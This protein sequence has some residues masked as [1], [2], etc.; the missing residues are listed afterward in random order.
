MNLAPA[1]VSGQAR[2]IDN[3]RQFYARHSAICSI[4]WLKQDAASRKYWPTD[5]V[6]GRGFSRG[7]ESSAHFPT[8]HPAAGLH[9]ALANLRC[10]DINQ[11]P[12]GTH[13]VVAT[14]DMQ[15]F[16]RDTAR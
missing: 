4:S 8:T 9:C 7:L 16:T 14:I 1:I 11:A 5:T 15:N 3:S 13:N 10:H 12:G 2:K 6:Y